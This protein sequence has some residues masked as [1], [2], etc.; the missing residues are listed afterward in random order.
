[1]SGAINNTLEAYPLINYLVEKNYPITALKIGKYRYQNEIYTR[2]EALDK[3]RKYVIQAFVL[4]TKKQQESM[5]KYPFYRSYTQKNPFGVDINPSCAIAVQDEE[6]K[7]WSFYSA[8]DMTEYTEK[9]YLDYKLALNR[10]EQRFGLR[11]IRLISIVIYLCLTVSLCYFI[12]YI[13]SSNDLLGSIRIPFNGS[14]V[15]LFVT[16]AALALLPVL[17]PYIKGF[18]LPG[19][20][21]DL[22]T[23]K[24]AKH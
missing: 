11:L 3:K 8:S 10:F 6:S 17:F 7:K 21:V 12:L 16:L 5:N 24:K 18:R 15:G 14:I 1:M 4:M 9:Y 23:E 20:G 13:L 22:K 19:F 2:I